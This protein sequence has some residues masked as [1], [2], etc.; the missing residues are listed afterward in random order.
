MSLKRFPQ[1]PP[2]VNDVQQTNDSS[3]FQIVEEEDLTALRNGLYEEKTKKQTA[4]GVKIFR[5]TFD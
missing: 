4:L 5:G 2:T 1:Q 3:C